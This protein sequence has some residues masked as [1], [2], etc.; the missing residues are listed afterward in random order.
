MLTHFGSS[1]CPRCETQLVQDLDE[2]A[3]AALPVP[4]HRD[5]RWLCPTCG[6]SRPVVYAVVRET[7]PDNS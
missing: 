3:M 6:Y 7:K 4:Q 1:H 5:Q 2:A